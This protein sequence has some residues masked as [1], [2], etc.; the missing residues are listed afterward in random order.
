MSARDKVVAIFREL[1]GDASERLAGD[2][3]L[4]D[5]NTRITA[6]LTAGRDEDS[7]ILHNDGIGFHLVDWQSEAAFL[8]ALALF[9]ERFTDEEIREGVEAF[10]IH[11][12]SHVV[13]AARLAGVSYDTFRVNESEPIKAVDPTPGNAHRDSGGLSEG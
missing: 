8:V 7:I 13:E 1:A 12:P 4:A 2:R 3:Y 5:V 10:L 11:A 9:P 6:A